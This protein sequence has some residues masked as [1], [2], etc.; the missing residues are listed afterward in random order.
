MIV[1]RLAVSGFRHIANRYELAP[2]ERLTIVG[3]PN[4]TGKSTLLDALYAVLLERFNVTGEAAVERFAA[5]G[6][7]LVPRIELDFRRDG[8]RYRLRKSFLGEKS[9][10][11]ERREGDRYVAFREGVAVDDFLRG[12]F[13]AEAPGRGV[14]DAAKHR[15][16]AHVLWAPNGAAF[17]ALPQDAGNRIRSLLGGVVVATEAERSIEARIR[18]RYARYFTAAGKFA[19]GAGSANI[20]ALHEAVEAAKRAEAEARSA[21]ERLENVRRDYEDRHAEAQR[22]ERRRLEARVRIAELSTAVA[23]YE[24]LFAARSR[25]AEEEQRWRAA[26]DM[27]KQ[28]IDDITALRRER[29]TLTQSL[30][31]GRDELA[32]LGRR[33]AERNAEAIDAASTHAALAAAERAIMARGDEVS[34][35]EAYVADRRAAAPLRALLARASAGAQTLAHL[36]AQRASALAPDEAELNDLRD[37]ESERRELQAKVDG[38]SLAIELTARTG[39]EI[40]VRI[41]DGEP[42]RLVAAGATERVSGTDEVVLEIEGVATI[43]ARGS[44]GAR[45]A[46]TRLARVKT[47]IAETL[48]QFNA[49]SVAELEGRY[50]R[51]VELER[52]TELQERLLAQ[53][54]DGRSVEELR[55]EI[56]RIEGRIALVEQRWPQWRSGLPDAVAMRVSFEHEL[57]EAADARI[58]AG[59]AVETAR[60]RCATIDAEIA[61]RRE[62]LHA[63]ELEDE[64]K[65]ARLEVLES[66]GLDD[67]RRA[68]ALAEAALEWNAARGAVAAQE[69]ALRAY[70]ADPRSEYELETNAEREA[71]ERYERAF[72]E[73]KKQLALV[74]ELS[75][76]GSYRQLAEAEERVAACE[77]RRDA[78]LLEAEAARRLKTA[79]DTVQRNRIDA[80]VRPIAVRAS[81]YLARIAGPSLGRISIDQSLTPSGVID[82]GTAELLSVEGTLS[83]G[84]REQVFLAARF[85]LAEIVA[86]DAGR[87]LFVLDDAVTATDPA[88]FRRILQI[89]EEL[90]RER[91][92]I[93]VATC[94]PSRYYGLSDAKH[95]DLRAEL[96]GS[97]ALGSAP[98]R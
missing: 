77:Q 22:L 31:T 11:L 88:R 50:A 7:T 59:Q 20:P 37:A 28:R 79:L 92:Q 58:V 17:S 95:V 81:D 46:R 15:G 56:A 4:G 54:V 44:D 73:S 82:Q 1:E 69:Q 26:H 30:A 94:D 36:R 25:A 62:A 55:D 87:Q 91:L 10:S 45:S 16:L 70:G 21:V 61:S 96:A 83:A 97:V 5:R 33:L 49:T 41:G 98:T 38:A 57:R 64:R 68:A 67:E 8:V 90:S 52:E 74:E 43:V 76:H 6:R 40:A 89:L 24:R 47:T 51:A 27:R 72:G 71:S 34:D 75:Q 23:E 32:E 35:A 18:E 19:A 60:E 80:V 53:A 48:A 42:R 78:S 65:A 29:E 86:G 93:I 39:V 14:A 3:A 2:S 85:A 12:L 63:L 84:E 9:A 66:D 13:Y